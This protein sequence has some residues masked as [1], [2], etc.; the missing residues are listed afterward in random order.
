MSLPP[1][2][3]TPDH[4]G[5]DEEMLNMQYSVYVKQCTV[6]CAAH[7]MQCSLCD[8]NYNMHLAMHNVGSC[9]IHYTMH[10]AQ[11]MNA[12]CNV[13]CSLYN[14]QCELC[15]VVWLCHLLDAKL[16]S[17]QECNVSRTLSVGRNREENG[18]VECWARV[19][20]GV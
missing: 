10:N 11:H 5:A 17:C 16:A 6:Q 4:S 14:V 13:R 20:M 2:K 3:C 8:L 9:S 7:T 18:S 12:L 1:A 15:I 19:I